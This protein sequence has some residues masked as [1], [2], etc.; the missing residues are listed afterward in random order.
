MDV[1]E[2]QAGSAGLPVMNLERMAKQTK[3]WFKDVWQTAAFYGAYFIFAVAG[4]LV[5]VICAGPA[6]LSRGVGARF[7]GQKLIRALFVFL[8]G[9]LRA[10]GLIELD[11][12]ELSELRTAGGL[13]VVA[14]HPGLLDAVL[15]VSQL[16]PAVCLMKGSLARN[17]VLSGTARLAGYV[18]N[19]SGLG[20]VKK[21]EER[22]KEGVNL[23]VFPEGTRTM[24]GELPPFKMGF[25]LVA[26]LT[27]SPVQTIII[28]AEHNWLGKGW[29]FFKKPAFPVHYSLR[30]GR[31]F[32]P[33][34]GVDAKIFGGGVENYFRETLS[35][36]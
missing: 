22:L 19:E 13:I 31:R 17:I 35:K 32:Q 36:K 15:L 24:N 5:S 11:A 8:V 21:C 4:S 7:F 34:P 18:H 1:P 27:R 14:N 20:L 23:L 16:P 3:N 10:F 25:A 30:L 29:P 2:T 6:F 33:E 12:G 28:T 26:I 9:Y